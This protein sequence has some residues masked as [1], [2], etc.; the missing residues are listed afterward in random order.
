MVVGLTASRYE[1]L[2]RL[3]A[4]PKTRA[5]SF[6]VGP[7]LATRYGR[8]H[9][10]GNAAGLDPIGTKYQGG[11]LLIHLGITPV[12]SS[13]GRT[14]VRCVPSQTAAG[15]EYLSS[16]RRESDGFASSCLVSGKLHGGK[17]EMRP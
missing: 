8:I 7:F 13:V 16:S 10:A 4:S 6:G 2:A 5:A 11:L 12:K 14:M 1:V 15:R 9:T 17:G 3:R